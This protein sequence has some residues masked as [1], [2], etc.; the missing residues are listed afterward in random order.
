MDGQV[1][2][3]IEDIVKRCSKPLMDIVERFDPFVLNSKS[4]MPLI[5][6]KLSNPPTVIEQFVVGHLVTGSI[7]A[8]AHFQNSTADTLKVLP[9]VY[10]CTSEIEEELRTF[11]EIKDVEEF[12]FI[13]KGFIDQY[14]KYIHEMI[15][16]FDNKD[17]LRL[18]FITK[19][20]LLF[21]EVMDFYGGTELF[22]E[23]P[24][25]PEIV[26]DSMYLHL[27]NK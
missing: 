17:I 25:E 4:L 5:L 26:S 24:V 12:R 19:K 3:P 6:N 8:K 20:L 22:Q 15:D 2:A 13:T 9:V 16:K 10:N 27:F 21:N 1:D 18:K 23:E 14:V 7:V 11:Q